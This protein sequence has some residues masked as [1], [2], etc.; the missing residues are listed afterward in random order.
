MINRRSTLLRSCCALPLL[1]LSNPA[2][3]WKQ[4]LRRAQRRGQ[5]RQGG[6]N[7]HGLPGVGVHPRRSPSCRRR[8]ILALC[9]SHLRT[10]PRN[11]T[12]PDVK[13]GWLALL[14]TGAVA[15]LAP[16]LWL[17]PVCTSCAVRGSPACGASAGTLLVPK[18]RGEAISW[19]HVPAASSG[20]SSASVPVP[21]AQRMT[22]AARWEE[23]VTEMTKIK[24]KGR[25]QRRAAP[26]S[27]CQ[28]EI[29]VRT[30]EDKEVG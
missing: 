22:A 9:A 4:L 24:I 28:A 30:A 8:I 11:D 29:S 18:D 7:P 1:E 13:R 16:C 15:L 14:G 5:G 10:E 23:V 6:E 20:R 19:P 26:S 17:P 3:S 12:R 25:L 2:R 27:R 21:G